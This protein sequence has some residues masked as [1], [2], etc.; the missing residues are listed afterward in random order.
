M[1]K[2]RDFAESSAAIELGRRH[3]YLMLSLRVAP[4]LLTLGMVAAAVAVVWQAV[5]DVTWPA[6]AWAWIGAVVGGV[7]IA[8]GLVWLTL[9]AAERW[10]LWFRLRMLVRRY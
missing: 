6:N 10:D 8:A 5:P 7:G 4:W 3:P 2:L 9:R 1:G